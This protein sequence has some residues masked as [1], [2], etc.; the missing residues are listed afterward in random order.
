MKNT[1]NMI[2]KLNQKA[3][4]EYMTIVL[5]NVT[6]NVFRVEYSIQAVFRVELSTRSEDLILKF[7]S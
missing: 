4:P 5:C 6:S 2:V 3:P 7:R 1:L